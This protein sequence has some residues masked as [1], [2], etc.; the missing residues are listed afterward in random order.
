M[1]DEPDDV[2]REQLLAKVSRIQSLLT[3]NDCFAQV[4]LIEA[5]DN[6]ERAESLLVKSHRKVPITSTTK[7]PETNSAPAKAVVGPTGGNVQKEADVSFDE[8][9]LL[10]DVSA[11]DLFGDLDDN[12]GSAASLLSSSD[13][14]ASQGEIPTIDESH[15][16]VPPPTAEHILCLK[17]YFGHSSFRPLQW[18]IIRSVLIDRRDNLVIMATG[19]GK[20]LCYQFPAM[21]DK[22]R[23]MTIVVS[24]LISLMEDQVTSLKLAGVSACFLGSAQTDT[25]CLRDVEAGKYVLVYVTPEYLTVGS[26]FLKNIHQSVGINLV[27]IDEAHCVSQWGHDFRN[28]YRQLD[29]IRKQLPQVP[30]LALTATA[31]PSVRRDVSFS[32]KL[33]RPQVLCTSFDR[34]NLFFE[35]RPR[36]NNVAN[37]LKTFMTPVKET[38]LMT[39]YQ[40]PG[41]TI[42]YCPTKKMTE[43]VCSVLNGLGVKVGMY[44]AGLS[45]KH[46][47]DTHQGFLMDRLDCVVAT[48]AFGMG[49]DKPDVRLVIH[50]GV[51]KDIE[52]YYQ[53]MGRAGRDGDDSKCYVLYSY[54]DFVM[55][56]SLLGDITDKKFQVHKIEMI[57]KLEMYVSTT[58]CRRR[59]LLNHFEDIT[60]YG[61]KPKKNCCDNCTRALSRPANAGSDKDAVDSDGKRD[62]AKEAKQLLSAISMWQRGLQ[63]S[64]L[65]LR[66]SG[67]SKL[68]D[69]CRKKENYGVGQHLPENYWKAL[70]R[71][72]KN[73]RFIV[74]EAFSS[75]WS[76][77]QGASKFG[78]TVKLSDKGGAYLRQSKSGP[79][80]LSPTQDMV[81]V[82][83]QAERAAQVTFT[84]RNNPSVALGAQGLLRVTTVALERASSAIGGSADVDL[85][86]SEEQQR[87]DGISAALFQELIMVRA[88]LLSALSRSGMVT[89]A[90]SLVT[91]I[92]LQKM[93]RR[94]PSS[95]MALK[96]IDSLSDEKAEKYGKNF[97]DKI[98]SFC[99]EHGARL[100]FDPSSL[101]KRQSVEQVL[102]KPSC[103]KKDL[104]QTV[105]VSY[106]MFHEESQTLEQIATTRGIQPTTVGGHLVDAFQAGYPVDYIR[107]GFTTDVESRS[108]A[109]VKAAYES[110]GGEGVIRAAKQ[111][112]PSLEYWHLK[113]A[114]AL[115]QEA[116]DNTG[117]ADRTSSPKSTSLLPAAQQP[118]APSPEP[119]LVSSSYFPGTSP[120]Q[121]PC[122]SR[123]PYVQAKPTESSSTARSAYVQAKATGS[124]T[125]RS[126]YVLAKSS[127]AATGA[128]STTSPSGRAKQFA[129]DPVPPMKRQNSDDASSQR[130]LPTWMSSAGRGGQRQAVGGGTGMPPGKK[131]NIRL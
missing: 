103:M 20:S 55:W 129:P 29:C 119:A 40:F 100:D 107:A 57:S 61:T 33:Q 99:R 90:A 114:I 51:P 35:A 91:N 50:Y 28:S 98:V 96:N 111:S 47:R 70:G 73:E 92:A 121:L 17:K 89:S 1:E 34:P 102:V 105:V 101:V 124:S 118:S 18:K 27:A 56:K 88:G 45:V 15:D 104:S 67:S 31:T 81:E 66:G 53:E 71:M 26:S 59:T 120:S 95:I 93:A 116:S 5:C 25:S 63:T 126:P 19:Y 125:A 11:E 21:Y 106:N 14:D 87:E 10:G 115:L 69:W 127:A 37:D 68:P 109:A 130:S 9:S 122:Q 82:E 117:S 43:E 36:G 131:K 108:V 65:F 38:G 79:L 49:I 16:D 4:A 54:K 7:I 52:S 60:P 24:P 84:V 86:P 64:I 123:S 48:V 62:Y 39:H 74:D 94:R 41:S 78:C 22:A 30:I 72:L 128:G 12:D 77:G 113:M 23:G 3:D 75:G 58:E 83:Q 97:I 13:K 80:R 110:T 6:L 85:P 76:G 8:H 112:C 46:R 32:L 44:H 42:V 2:S